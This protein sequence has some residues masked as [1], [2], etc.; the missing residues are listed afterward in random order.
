M[1]GAAAL[2]VIA[3]AAA[4]GTGIAV[5]F[6]NASRPSSTLAIAGGLGCLATLALALA[7][8]EAA[9]ALG[10]V[11]LGVVF[12][13]PAPP[14]AVLMIVMAVAVVTGRFTL[15]RIPFPVFAL[16]GAFLVLNLVSAVFAASP[17]RVAFFLMITVYLCGF[18][19]W[20]TGFVDSVQRARMILVPLV[21]GAVTSAAI[22]VAVLFVSFP[23]K[24]LVDFSDGLR[25]R[26]FFKDP[27]VFGPFCVFV[28]LIV[29]SELLEPRLLRAR[30]AVKL[31]LLAVLALGV[32]FAYSRAAWLN[33]AVATVTMIVAY[34]LRRGGGRKAAAILVTL[35]V[36]AGA[37]SI[38]LAA[39]GS[40]GFLAS[41][42]H[43]QSYDV[44]RFAAQEEGLQ[45]VQSYPFGIGPG[46]F[47][48]DVDYAS[49]STYVRVLAEQGFLGLFV[50][51]SLLLA[52]LGLAA[53]N[54][55]L[56]RDTYGIASVP[57]LAGFCGILANS[58]FVDTLHWRHLWLAVG[59]IWAGA[60]R[61]SGEEPQV[62]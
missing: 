32:L 43:F 14:D 16:L 56:G 34:S 27:N 55:V 20:L 45:L 37:G 17:G 2:G 6:G 30:R 3:L 57:L 38:A 41:R 35:V 44:R 59:L 24:G 7:R 49:H 18:G 53:R 60:M 25:A 58:A 39:T 62:L 9:V 46:Q 8:Y 26:G 11:I 51:L 40:E 4:L 15:R 47:E 10:M 5:A 42:A 29:V 12:V 50:M 22:G 36:L 13:Q 28:A 23:G 61:S 54:V 1:R 33:A 19:V 21:A 48:L 31:I 52:T